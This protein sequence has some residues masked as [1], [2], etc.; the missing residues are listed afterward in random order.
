MRL[1]L[2]PPVGKK[3]RLKVK[4]LISVSAVALVLATSGAVLT[5]WSTD[6]QARTRLTV[7]KYGTQQ[8][9]EARVP[10]CQAN[11]KGIYRTQQDGWVFPYGYCLSNVA[12]KVWN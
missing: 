3:G 4:G 12:R 1:S 10:M 7:Y 5:A 11:V 2:L 9:Y 6:A 8:Y